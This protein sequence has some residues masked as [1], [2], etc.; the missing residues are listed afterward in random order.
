M[1]SWSL[2]TAPAIQM[3]VAGLQQLFE[4]N[5]GKDGTMFQGKAPTQGGMYSVHKRS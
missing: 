2:A 3:A 5:L 4:A 1:I